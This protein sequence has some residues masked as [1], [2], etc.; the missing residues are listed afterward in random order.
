MQKH[1]KKK[2]MQYYLIIKNSKVSLFSVQHQHGHIL[3]PLKSKTYTNDST[4]N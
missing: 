2:K 3:T 4:K 1:A